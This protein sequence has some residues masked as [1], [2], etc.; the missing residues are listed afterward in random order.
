MS[1]LNKFIGKSE[2]VEI[3][4]EVFII[5]PLC[6]GDFDLII[7]MSDKSD[8]EGAGKAINSIIKKTLKKAES[9]MT[10]EEYNSLPINFLNKILETILKVN[11]MET[12]S[13]SDLMDKF[14]P[15]V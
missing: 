10:D 2:E 11:G 7:K 13:E 6:G 8:F 5:E 15:K 14:K 12:G 4:G 1:R 3:D 9:E